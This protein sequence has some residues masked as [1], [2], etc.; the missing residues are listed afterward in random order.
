M[1]SQKMHCA[2]DITPKFK[3]SSEERM[4]LW[5]S[6]RSR[7]S[8][9]DTFGFGWEKARLYVRFSVD[10][11]GSGC[12]KPVETAVADDSY[13]SRSSLVVLCARS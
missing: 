8:T 1:M 7:Q 13:S 10:Y 5:Q 2:L 12:C 11:L 6:C 4:N 3:K 9:K